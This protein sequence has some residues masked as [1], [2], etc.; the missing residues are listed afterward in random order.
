MEIE[1]SEDRYCLSF[2]YGINQFT[3]FKPKQSP[4]AGVK[5]EHS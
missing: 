4:V 5:S 2:P 3:G 1:H